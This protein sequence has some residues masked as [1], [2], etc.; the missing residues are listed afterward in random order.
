MPAPF[1]EAPAGSRPENKRVMMQ[2][3][4][5]TVDEAYQT[6]DT[7]VFLPGVLSENVAQGGKLLSDARRY[8]RPRS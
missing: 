2:K 4:T 7:L 8:V 3:I 6:G 1:S 5:E